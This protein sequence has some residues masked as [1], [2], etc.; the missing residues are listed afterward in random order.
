MVWSSMVTAA[1]GAG[2]PA[3]LIAEF[4]SNDA[5][6]YP[7]RADQRASDS[8]WLADGHT[9]SAAN[10]PT[11]AKT[12]LTDMRGSV[13]FAMA[14]SLVVRRPSEFCKLASFFSESGYA[15]HSVA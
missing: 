12:T 4:V 9:I 7:S 14:D 8:A 15:H 2:W 13:L 10:T 1:P 3:T 11:P 6:A 5:C